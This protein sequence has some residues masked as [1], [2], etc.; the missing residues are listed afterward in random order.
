M[1]CRDD[2]YDRE[3]VI[4]DHSAVR[5]VE[6]ERDHLVTMLCMAVR[7][8]EA[9]SLPIPNLIGPWWREHKKE[10]KRRRAAQQKE[11]ERMKKL[12]DSKDKLKKTLTREE[13]K[14]LRIN[15]KD[16]T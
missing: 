15:L 6:R 13:L 7:V 2:D 8:I 11:R 4:V 16:D 9:N 3:R 5:E 1:P 14:L 10:D 12:E